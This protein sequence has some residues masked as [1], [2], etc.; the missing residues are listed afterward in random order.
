MLKHRPTRLGSGWGTSDPLLERVGNT[1]LVELRKLV[2]SQTVRVFAKCEWLNPGGSVKD[3][4]ALSMI[5]DGERRGLLTP[6]KTI[7][8]ATSGNT[9][10][11]YALIAARRGYAVELAIPRN[12]S[13]ERLEILRSYGVE[14]LLTD[15]LQG[16]DGAIETARERFARHPGRYFYADQYGNPANWQAH[17]QSTGPEILRQTGGRVTHFVA[18]LGTTGTFTGVSRF[19]KEQRPAIRCI[20]VIPSSPLHGLEGLKHLP[21]TLHVPPIFDATLLEQRLEVETEEAQEIAKRLAGEEGLLVGPSGGAAVAA[22]L[23]I[24]RN[25]DN[26][27]V[28]TLL[29]DGGMKYLSQMTL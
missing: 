4:P 10:I 17:Y 1:P 9:G 11:A 21:S 6:G 22:A 2:A 25:L 27:V 26:G 14:L 8:D 23:R 12:T 24:A 5:L 7:L 16:S 20:G 19:L 15:P 28:V 3:R 13:R 18:G 29:P